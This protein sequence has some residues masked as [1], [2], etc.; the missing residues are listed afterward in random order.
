M[1]QYAN[2]T[3]RQRAWRARRKGP[4]ARQ[5]GPTTNPGKAEI[6]QGLRERIKAM[7]GKPEVKAE[8]F[9]ENP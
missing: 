7:E 9:E 4:V 5:D 2:A 8:P 6:L 3:E 1:R